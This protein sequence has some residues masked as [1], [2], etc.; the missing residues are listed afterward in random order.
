LISR[1]SQRPFL[2]SSSNKACQKIYQSLPV[3][4]GDLLKNPRLWKAILLQNGEETSSGTRGLL[5]KTDPLPAWQKEEAMMPRLWTLALVIISLLVAPSLAFAVPIV[6]SAAG[7]DAGDIQ[8]AVN[9]FRADLG[10][11][12]NLNDPGPLSTGRREINWD[13]GGAAAPVLTNMPKDLF[14]NNRGAF[15]GPDAT[16]FSISGNGNP[17]NPEFGNI[18][19]TYQ[20]RFGTFSSPRLFSPTNSILTEQTFFIPGTNGGIEALTKGFGAVFTSVDLANTTKI[21]YF[22]LN[23]TSL[24]SFFVP[25]GTGGPGSLSFL[26]VSFDDAIISRVVITSGNT[27]LGPNDGLVVNG[28]RIDVVAMDDFIFGEPQPVPEAS[29]L[30]L[31]GSALA[32]FAGWRLMK[33]REGR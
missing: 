1:P 30:F 13:G 5:V 6:R 4:A 29:S 33:A 21:Q 19:P 25:Q 26:G 8:A 11:V 10:G 16:V 7:A 18:N 23:N 9:A 32:G 14:L 3:R 12:N 31:L 24:G 17:Q 2:R 20:G 28:G 15:F 27:I 22:G